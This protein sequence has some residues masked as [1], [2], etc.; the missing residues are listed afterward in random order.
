MDFEV[1][2]VGGSYAG[3]SAATSLGRALRKVLVI[4]GG[5]PCNRQTPYSHNF[6][7]NDGETPSAIIHKATEQ[8]QAYKTVTSLSDTVIDGS[9]IENGFEV[10]T[11]S[12]QKFTAAKLL[13]ATGI[14]DVLPPLA[15]FAECWGISVLHCPYCHGYEVRHQPTGILGN[16]EAIFEYVKLISN[17]TK[18]ITLFT[19]GK[20]T[21]T[22]EQLQELRSKKIKIE[23]AKVQHLVHE[24]G[25][26]KSIILQDDCAYNI[27]ALYARLPFTQHC[28]LPQ[29]LGCEIT[30]EGYI[31]VD[32]FY[33]TSL[34][35]I[36]AAGDNMTMMRSVAVAVAAGTAT[37]AMIN[38]DLVIEEF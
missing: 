38:R 36:Y 30:D 2:I 8:L 5:K 7:T 1:I 25:K 3:L 23:E 9:K 13:F 14:T 19:N 21:L 34:P 29:Q 4:D 35:G 26:I 18:D 16:G 31:Q 22:D 37:G 33:K 32:S 11:L 10:V 27:A 6:L 28:N 12:G 20:A 17:W 15:G 24:G